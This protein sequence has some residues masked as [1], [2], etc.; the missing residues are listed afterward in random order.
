[1]GM[2]TNAYV[3]WRFYPPDQLSGRK[4]KGACQ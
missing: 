3:W 1:L 2:R 4:P